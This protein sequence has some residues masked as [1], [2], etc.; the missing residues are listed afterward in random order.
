M[1]NQTDIRAY[2]SPMPH[3]PPPKVEPE[4][5]IIETKK[6]QAQITE[7]FHTSA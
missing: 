1:D 3:F 6:R 7:F 2:C 5:Q 4:V